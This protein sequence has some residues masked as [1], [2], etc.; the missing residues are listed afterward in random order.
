GSTVSL[1]ASRWRVDPDRVDAARDAV[2]DQRSLFR[3]PDRASAGT[4]IAAG[5]GLATW[6]GD[7][8]G[9]GRGRSDDRPGRARRLASGSGPA[10]R[11]PAHAVHIYRDIERVPRLA[12]GRR[13]RAGCPGL[14]CGRGGG[15][16]ARGR[17]PGA[18]ALSARSL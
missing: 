1:D 14:P 6:S 4:G 18:W 9:A 8:D 15:R 12:V 16:T 13:D 7:V 3:S 11:L 5:T 10:A 2:A 17:A